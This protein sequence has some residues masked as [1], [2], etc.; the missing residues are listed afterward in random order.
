MTFESEG[1]SDERVGLGDAVE[2]GIGGR[3][4]VGVSLQVEAGKEVHWGDVVEQASVG[5]H[6]DHFAVL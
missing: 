3:V 1:S 5:I 6:C 2:G 4:P